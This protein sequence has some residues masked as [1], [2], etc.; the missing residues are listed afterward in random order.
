MSDAPPTYAFIADLPDS[1]REAALSL[2][3]SRW[4]LTRWMCNESLLLSLVAGSPRKLLGQI[5]A[6]YRTT[7]SY[8]ERTVE[9]LGERHCRVH[10][11]RDFF[12]PAYNSGL[13][14]AGLELTGARNPVVVGRQTGPLDLVCEASWEA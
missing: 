13:L 3:A 12:P 14:T 7:V 9:W 10:Y 6:S 11:R 5:Q 8:G 2:G 4:D 1:F